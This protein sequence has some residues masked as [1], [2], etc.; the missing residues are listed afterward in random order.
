MRIDKY[1]W[2]VRLFK[3]RSDSAT[4]CTKGWIL[5]NNQSAKPSKTVKEG[6][7]ISVKHQSIYREYKVLNLIKNRVG[8]KL[9]PENIEEITPEETLFKLKVQKEFSRISTPQRDRNTGRP[10][11]KER[12]DLDQFYKK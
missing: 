1:L 12:R 9:V 3:T 11:K 7:I 6:D 10:T 2:A 5:I 8:A 4:A